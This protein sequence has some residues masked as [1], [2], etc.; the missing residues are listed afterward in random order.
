MKTL[1]IFLPLFIALIIVLA[2]I[3]RPQV[4][5]D[6]TQSILIFTS[7]T[8]PHCQ[9]V[10]D[11][12]SKNNLAEKLPITFVDVAASAN[13]KLLV[14]KATQCGLDTSSIGVPMYFYQDNCISG[15][16]PIIDQLDKMLQ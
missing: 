8:C 6:T 1:K 11:Y 5:G 7:K 9:V 14:D 10:K 16:Q 15:D 3:N 13:S 4:I 2:L 12:I